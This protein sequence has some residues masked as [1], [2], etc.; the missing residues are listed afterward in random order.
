MKKHVSSSI[1]LLLLLSLPVAAQTAEEI[2]E[3]YHET[4]GGED[5][6]RAIKAIHAETTT[7]V[8]G[9]FVSV[10]MKMDSARGLFMKQLLPMGE[11][12]IVQNKEELWVKTPEDTEPQKKDPKKMGSEMEIYNNTF[13]RPF[14]RF[15]R[16]AELV[17][18]KETV[19]SLALKKKRKKIKKSNNKKVKC[20]VITAKESSPTEE[21]MKN[22]R[23][24]GIETKLYFGIKDRL[25]HRV[26]R[27]ITSAET[28]KEKTVTE[29]ISD[30]RIVDDILVPHKVTVIAQ[31]GQPPIVTRVNAIRINPDFPDDLFTIEEGEYVD[32]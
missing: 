10:T 9:M 32:E 7:S 28:G 24:K 18:Y 15:M 29:E 27:I 6:V 5:K 12:I 4:I 31:E 13:A 22:M 26:D 8:M 14:M 20:Y 19:T 30:Y 3:K 25:L 2:L 17:D 1:I 11:A 23:I 16:F 21:Q